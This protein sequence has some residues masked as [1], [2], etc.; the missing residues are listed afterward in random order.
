MNGKYSKEENSN[1][2]ETFGKLHKL[3][4]MKTEQQILARYYD[5]KNDYVAL[6]RQ[7]DVDGTQFDYNDELNGMFNRI[8]E[9]ELILGI[10]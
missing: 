8:Q 7:C 1:W 5:L 9:L 2:K 3:R 4:D 10:K 6:L